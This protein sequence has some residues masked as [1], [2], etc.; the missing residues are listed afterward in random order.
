MRYREI[1]DHY[2]ACLD[3]HGDTHLGVDW[4]N[5]EDAQRR[6]HVMLQI[7]PPDTREP[8]TLLDFGCGAAHLYQHLLQCG[9]DARILYSGVDLSTKFIALCRAKFP[10]V[11]F[12]CL[13]LLRDEAGLPDFDYIVMNGVFTEKRSLCQEEMLDYFQALVS[14][15]FAKTRRGLAFNV[16]SKHVDW[17]RDDLFHLSFDTLAGFLAKNVSRA[18]VIRHDYRLYEYTVYL[19]R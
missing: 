9:L 17:E 1:V 8:V 18:F 6:Y 15:V 19:Y 7:V 4:P 14:R 11:P 13:D 5:P 12:Y 16:M 2:E 3:R 10:A